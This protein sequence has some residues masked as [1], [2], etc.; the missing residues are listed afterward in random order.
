MKCQHSILAHFNNDEIADIRL[1]A[2]GHRLDPP[3]MVRKL[4]GE[5]INGRRPH[6]YLSEGSDRSILEPRTDSSLGPNGLLKPRVTGPGAKV[7][8]SA[9]RAK[10]PSAPLRPKPTAAQERGIIQL[11]T[12]G[13]MSLAEAERAVMEAHG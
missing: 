1:L 6:V 10:R 4:V 11:V 9:A 5:A 12:Y 3:E 7:S 13:S 8:P 2:E